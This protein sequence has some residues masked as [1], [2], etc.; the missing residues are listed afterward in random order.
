ME[1][2]RWESPLTPLRLAQCLASSCGMLNTWPGKQKKKT[3]NKIPTY[4]WPFF[5]KG[6]IST[7]RNLDCFRDIIYFDQGIYKNVNFQMFRVLLLVLIRTYL[8]W[9]KIWSTI[10]TTAGVQSS[11]IV[12][13]IF[14]SL[15]SDCVIGLN[16][17]TGLSLY[18]ESDLPNSWAVVKAACKPSSSMTEQLL[19]GSHTVP[20]SAIPRVSHVW[21]PHKSYKEPREIPF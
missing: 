2:I 20:T 10:S 5:C 11:N 12:W 18:S 15:K 9:W 1:A 6:L 13:D 7:G 4:A 17:C 21:E 14:L 19:L 3:H 8:K 16:L